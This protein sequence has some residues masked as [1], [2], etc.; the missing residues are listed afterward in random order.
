MLKNNSRIAKL[1]TVLTKPTHK[2]KK[3][4]LRLCVNM[5]GQYLEDCLNQSKSLPLDDPALL[6]QICRL[7]TVKRHSL[8]SNDNG[9]PLY[10]ES[11]KA[12]A[13]YIVL[14]GEVEERKVFSQTELTSVI[15]QLISLMFQ[16]DQSLDVTQ[17]LLNDFTTS[18]R[19]EM[20]IA[21]NK[22]KT[23]SATMIDETKHTTNSDED[24]NG[25]ETKNVNKKVDEEDA[26]S[27]ERNTTSAVLKDITSDYYVNIKPVLTKWG[28]NLVKLIEKVRTKPPPKDKLP[29]EK[30]MNK[31]KGYLE[32]IVQ[33]SIKCLKLSSLQ[34]QDRK[35]LSL[36]SQRLPNVRYTEKKAFLLYE[37]ITKIENIVFQIS[38]FLCK[39]VDKEVLIASTSP[40][41]RFEY[42]NVPKA[43]ALKAKEDGRKYGAVRKVV[44]A[45]DGT[46]GTV[47]FSKAHASYNGT[48]I[49]TGMSGATLA[50]LNRKLLL[51]ILKDGFHIDMLKKTKFLRSIK[52]FKM[53]SSTKIIEMVYR[54]EPETFKKDSKIIARGTMAK[55]VYIVYNG[56]VSLY[57]PI[58][59]ISDNE[60][61]Y[62][63]ISDGPRGIKIREVGP[64]AVLG[65][66]A[67]L[68]GSLVHG[69][70]EAI[71]LSPEVE[72][73]KLKRSIFEEMVLS[74]SNATKVFLNTAKIQN[75]N[76]DMWRKQWSNLTK[77]IH[78]PA[79]QSIYA[80]MTTMN[81]HE[82]RKK[83]VLKVQNETAKKK[84]LQSKNK[85]KHISDNGGNTT[86]AYTIESRNT[87]RS[88]NS[89]STWIKTDEERSQEH[90]R[91]KAQV[92]LGSEQDILLAVKEALREEAK[93]VD[94]SH[95]DKVSEDNTTISTGDGKINVKEYT[96]RIG[97]KKG[98]KRYDFDKEIDFKLPRN[99]LLKVA[100][101]IFSVVQNSKKNDNK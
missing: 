33:L 93:H 78:P 47:T 65:E 40:K 88:R 64:G 4:D 46:I 54:M 73:L 94:N 44:G 3:K 35:L 72:T 22:K 1:Y 62:K 74:S 8:I 96:L 85:N 28:E 36:D 42:L 39:D 92:L 16:F 41:E 21:R 15:E 37:L 5:L 23:E 77:I 13:A 30:N 70:T 14:Q 67:I 80:S 19:S 90:E 91:Y 9:A 87:N 59:K 11:E 86:G 76:K 56:F 79:Q 26:A 31:L 89:V 52:E 58:K 6:K 20:I 50:I 27:E 17:N 60:Y 83:L 57:T 97:A 63:N 10:N 48:A 61:V 81:Q 2:R 82:M 7:I 66:T 84:Y 71:A 53:W 55:Y 49:C 25:G 12:E 43:T 98:K 99:N 29:K 75:D 32:N 45:W 100:K 34:K 24:N 51:P 101:D 38:L 68:K 18:Y 95:L 69:F